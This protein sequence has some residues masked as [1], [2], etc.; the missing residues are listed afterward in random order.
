MQTEGLKMRLRRAGELKSYKLIITVAFGFSWKHIRC[1]TEGLSVFHG[2]ISWEHHSNWLKFPAWKMQL[3][4]R[5]GQ[6]A[7]HKHSAIC[8]W[9]EDAAR[10]R[11]NR[12]NRTRV[13][14]GM[15]SS[16]CRQTVTLCAYM[17]ATTN[18]P[19]AVSDNFQRA[20][21]WYPQINTA[22]VSTII[23]ESSSSN[24]LIKHKQNKPGRS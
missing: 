11:I 9:E 14:F 4:K 10:V 15:H 5:E 24:V 13:I 6:Y 22:S 20:L 21:H 23:S 17:N 1:T 2:K 16:K 3:I 7:D 19:P 8:V 18:C 12:W